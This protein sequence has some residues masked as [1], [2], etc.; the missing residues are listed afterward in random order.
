[1]RSIALRWPTHR[2]ATQRYRSCR[3]RCRPWPYAHPGATVF[4]H[5]VGLGAAND[6]ALIE[7]IGR[8]PPGKSQLPVLTGLCADHCR[9]PGWRWAHVRGYSEDPALVAKYARAMVTGCRAS[10]AAA[11]H[12]TGTCAGHHQAFSRRRRHHR[13]PRQFDN[14]AD[15]R[16]LGMCTAGYP[17]GID[18]GA[19]TVMASYN[20]WQGTKMHGNTRC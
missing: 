19:L 18:A 2:R 8:R 14:L 5:N 6:V 4:P 10:P 16:T 17:A 12:G 1:M 11:N 9:G 20:S 15:E 13:W 3:N 7:K